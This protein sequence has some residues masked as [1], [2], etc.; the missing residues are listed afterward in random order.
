MVQ[1]RSVKTYMT[2][3][4]HKT[5]TNHIYYNDC[6]NKDMPQQWDKYILGELEC[7]NK[8]VVPLTCIYPIVE[9]LGGVSSHRQYHYS[10]V[11][12]TSPVS[13]IVI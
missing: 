6:T 2:D 11:K 3:T 4:D 10:R 9:V 8:R 1:L 7:L 13:P 12:N 5:G